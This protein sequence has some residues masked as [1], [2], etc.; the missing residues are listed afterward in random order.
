MQVQTQWNAYCKEIASGTDSAAIIDT[1]GKILAMEGLKGFSDAESKKIA[2]IMTATTQTVDLA[3]EGM[4]IGDTQYLGKFNSANQVR[5][6]SANG[7]GLTVV[8]TYYVIV[9]AIS[10]SRTAKDEN[11]AL[12]PVL[13]KIQDEGY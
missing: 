13:A 12:K 11:D 2:S 3:K 10:K 5:A 6:L 4:K 8:K 1:A 7:A 9:I